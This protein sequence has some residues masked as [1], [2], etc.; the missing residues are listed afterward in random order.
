MGGGN[1][2]LG[3]GDGGGPQGSRASF[4][5]MAPLAKRGRALFLLALVAGCSSTSDPVIR[6]DHGVDMTPGRADSWVVPSDGGSAE[7]LAIDDAHY[8]FRGDAVEHGEGIGEPG[9]GDGQVEA[10]LQ[11]D[12]ASDRGA[13]AGLDGPSSSDFVVDGRAD[14]N[15]AA[16]YG[17]VRRG[18][19]PMLDG[20]GP[21][22]LAIYG[23]GLPPPFAAPAAK[24]K[25]EAADLAEGDAAVDYAIA[26]LPGPGVYTLYAFLDDNSNATPQLPFGAEV[27]D[28][29]D[30]VAAP[31]PLE[32]SGTQPQRLDIVLDTVLGGVTDAGAGG[33]A[34]VAVAGAL[35]GTLRLAVT[36]ALDARGTVLITLHA[37]PPPSPVL[38]Q[39]ILNDA[40]LGSP[41][42]NVDFFIGDVPPGRYFLDAML[43]D[44][45]NYNI[46]FPGPDKDDLILARPVMLRVEASSLAIVDV[47]FD[48]VKP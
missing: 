6:A 26:A 48:A 43:D 7:R 12:A 10:G 3:F 31:I 27:A 36:P 19:L 29:G 45:S 4:P 23:A 35:R 42:A 41:Y 22:Y 18:T 24:L 37:A 8:E 11:R 17:L 5:S 15:G 9:A 1:E 32:I 39:T 38:A 40:D 13:E 16:L 46:F 20:Q 2:G 30:L 44:N 21:I 28:N 33:D 47:A 14:A 34:G 25:I